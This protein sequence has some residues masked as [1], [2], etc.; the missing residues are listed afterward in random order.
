M[1]ESRIREAIH[2]FLEKCCKNVL[3]ERMV[4]YIVKELHTGRELS[5][6]LNDPY[7]KGRLDEAHMAHVLGNKE[8][9]TAYEQRIKES[10]HAS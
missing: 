10:L 4:D 9:L 6:V 8:L 2:E 7:I 3:E 1:P 5:D